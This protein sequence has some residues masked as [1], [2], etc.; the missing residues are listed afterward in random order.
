MPNT[1]RLN[2]YNFFLQVQRFFQ[3]GQV[4]VH[5]LAP[6][7]NPQLMRPQVAIHQGQVI[8]QPGQF[9]RPQGILI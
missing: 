9:T 4:V 6:G 5:Q 1:P 8:Q 2:G 7:Q 3:P